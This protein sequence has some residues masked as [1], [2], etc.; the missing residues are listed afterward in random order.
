MAL[1]DTRGL[2]A[3]LDVNKYRLFNFTV[4]GYTA[5]FYQC[6]FIRTDYCDLGR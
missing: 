4:E 1:T 6:L 5:N 3:V 2:V